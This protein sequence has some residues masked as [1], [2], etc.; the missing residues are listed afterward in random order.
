MT[1]TR[2]T[3][4]LTGASRGI[5]PYI[6]RSL[7]AAGYQPHPHHSGHGLGTTYHE[8]PRLVPYNDLPL[9]PGMVLTLEPGVYPAGVG[10]VRL[11]EVV[12]VTADGCERLTRHL[13]AV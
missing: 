2:A 6:A 8:E 9:E 3:A 7:A 5:G 1:S 12:L 4:L 11:E 10:G 13:D